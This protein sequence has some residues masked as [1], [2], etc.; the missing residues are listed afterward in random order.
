MKQHTFLSHE[1][2]K[3][4]ASSKSHAPF[5][6]F[7]VALI[8]IT[9]HCPK[10]LNSKLF[11]LWGCHIYLCVGHLLTMIMKAENIDNSKKK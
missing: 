6:G 4:V 5:S 9:L 8:M 7:T 10:T 3:G 11:V 2:K 1:V